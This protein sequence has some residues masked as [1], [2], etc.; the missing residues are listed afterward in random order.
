MS[1]DIVFIHSGLGNQM[2]QYAFY[3]SRKKNN[4]NTTCD[5]GLLKNRNIHN[6]FELN[7]IFGI[8]IGSNAFHIFI[9]RVLYYSNFIRSLFKIFNIGI[10]SDKESQNYNKRINYFLGYWQDEKNFSYI[11]EEIRKV[12]LFKRELLS[13]ECTAIQENIIQCNSVAI[14]IRRG[15][16]TAPQFQKIYGNIC[17]IDYYHKAISTILD[18]IPNPTFYIFSNDIEWVKKN[19]QIP[20]PIYI[21]FNKGKKSWQDMYLMSQ[22]KHNIIA[23]STFSWWGA[24]LN[25]NPNKIVICPHK[26]DNID[27][28]PYIFLNQWIKI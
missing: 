9:I 14:H 5:M 18:L 27:S 1:K 23:N 11:G 28:S 13:K 2:F 17:T 8:K 4:P 20:N 25:N 19:I 10:I 15:D 12:F 3:L 16:Y 26:F 21:D 6:G 7:N 22:C 24:Y